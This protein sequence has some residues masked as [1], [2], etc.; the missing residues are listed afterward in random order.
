[1]VRLVS[2]L[3]G[4]G[5]VTLVYRFT[6]KVAQSKQV[7]LIAAFFTAFSSYFILISQM[8]R[9]HALA[10]FA[11]LL[12]FYFF[13]R[14]WSGGFCKGV[15]WGYLLSFAFVGYVDYP[16]FIYVGLLTNGIFAYRYRR[17]KKLASLA[18]WL[19]GQLIVALLCSPM[20]WFSIIVSLSGRWWMV[21]HESPR[22]WVH[23]VA[24]IFSH[25]RFSLARI[26]SVELSAVWT[27]DAGT[28]RCSRRSRSDSPTQKL[29]SGNRI[30]YS[31]A[32]VS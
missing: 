21:G 17:K 32:P 3:S 2:I 30:S 18:R 14:L 8:A 9:Y 7:A 26:F 19:T 12:T 28:P 15:W 16:H 23:I 22:H 10:G 4:F 11:S 27:G 20:V 5:I 1:M 31:S 24:G 29:E 13:Y 6:K 25:L